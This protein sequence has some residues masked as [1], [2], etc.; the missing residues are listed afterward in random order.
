MSFDV[1]V[2]NEALHTW[3]ND[4]LKRRDHLIARRIRYLLTRDK[5][6]ERMTFTASDDFDL[7]TKVVGYSRYHLTME[8]KKTY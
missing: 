8:Y 1:Y 6:T 2:K 4:R 7:G 5:H 3:D